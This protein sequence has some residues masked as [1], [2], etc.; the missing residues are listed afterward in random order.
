[1]LVPALRDDRTPA[2]VAHPKAAGARPS[3]QERVDASVASAV[4]EALAKVSTPA[5]AEL[6]ARQ[7]AFDRMLK[8]RAEMEREANALAQLSIEQAKRDDALMRE[9]LKLI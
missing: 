2:R 3:L 5:D 7:S 6:A 1:M 8:E 4:G 9:W